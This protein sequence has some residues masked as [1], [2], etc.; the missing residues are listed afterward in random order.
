MLENSAS[1][2]TQW[3]HQAASFLVS[4]LFCEGIHFHVRS[5]ERIP[6]NYSMLIIHLKVGRG[7]MTR[8]R[9]FTDCSIIKDHSWKAYEKVKDIKGQAKHMYWY[10]FKA[11]CDNTEQG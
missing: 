5:L 11:F 4:L 10:M 8:M 2:W 9:S 7:N 6:T 3:S 1:A